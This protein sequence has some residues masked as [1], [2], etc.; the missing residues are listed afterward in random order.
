[1]VLS[2]KVSQS[3]GR[4]SFVNK[5]QYSRTVELPVRE[6]SRMYRCTKLHPSCNAGESPRTQQTA[7][8]CCN[9]EQG[10]N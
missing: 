6:L 10:R 7:T 9:Y 4:C 1:M 5:K 8:I 2:L 3:F